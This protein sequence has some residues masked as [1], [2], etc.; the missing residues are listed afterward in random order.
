MNA[1]LVSELKAPLQ[2]AATRARI[3]STLGPATALAGIGW[4][5]VQPYRITLLHPR[6]QDFWWLFVEPP[7]LVIAVGLFFHFVVVPGLLED[8]E[9]EHAAAK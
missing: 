9:E 6:G 4:A 8:L 2:R 3:I 1:E 7:L 5:L